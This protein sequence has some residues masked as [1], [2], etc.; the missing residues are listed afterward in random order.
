M[1]IAVIGGG[2]GGLYFSRLIKRQWPEWSVDVFEQNP[3]DATFG[4]GV[5]L[6][7]TSL[8]RLGD[9]D[10]EFVEGLTRIAVFNN[11]QMISLQ[12]EELFIE[13]AQQGASVERLAMLN[14]LRELC[15]AV[16]VAI[17]YEHRLD[18]L[19]ECADYDLIVASDGANSQIRTEREEAF[20]VSGKL[21]NNRFAWYGIDRALASSALVFRSA[22]G[23]AFIAHY[24]AYTDSM[25]TFVAECDE[26]AWLGAGL[27]DKSDDER[28]A[29]F[30][31]L[32]AHELDG[33]RLIDNRSVYRR[34]PAVAADTWV[35]GNIVLIGDAQRVAHFSIGSGTRLALDDAYALFDSIKKAPDLSSALAQFQEVRRPIRMRFAEAATRSYEWYEQVGQ[36]MEQPLI[37]FV[38]DFMTRTGRIDDERLATYAPGFAQTYAQYRLQQQGETVTLQA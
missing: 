18:T 25:S 27:E 28:R 23:G 36:A 21:L 3:H 26:A 30:E 31:E 10:P 32:F 2:P 5:T 14:L 29:L 8:G 34:F 17:H 16:G 20:S 4:F 19:A 9:E 38:Y 12:G 37:E 6:G 24:Y 15:Q 13:Y 22:Y 35:D 1:R 7:G 11:Q 33:G